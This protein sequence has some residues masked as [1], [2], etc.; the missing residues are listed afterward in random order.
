MK[1]QIIK[2]FNRLG[3]SIQKV[4]GS[5]GTFFPDIADA[6]FWK[7]YN[8][9]KAFTMTSVERMYALYQSVN[10]V[11]DNQIPGDFV[12]CGVWRGGSSMM[13]GHVLQ[14]RGVKDRKIFLFDTFEGMPAATEN[15]E[16]FAGKQAAEIM[17]DNKDNKNA[18][19]WCLADL[20]DVKNNMSKTGLAENQIVY[21]KGM[22]ENTIP[23]AEISGE[24]SLLRL[25]T[26]WYESTKHE[27]IH[28][29][30]KVAQNG[31]VIIDDYGHWKGSRKAVDEY[32]A[33]KGLKPLLQRIDYTGRLMMKI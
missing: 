1:K 25:D 15:D 29:Y 14:H 23:N 19:I 21:V 32:F 28:M 2:L 8:I 31:V 33:E 6:E 7:F 11:L 22:V 9:S 17:S 13:I 10:Y 27:L 20:A 24:I 18:T 4:G 12:E 5:S 26:D 3:Y 30:P 16:D